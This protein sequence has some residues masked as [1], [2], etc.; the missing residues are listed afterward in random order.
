MARHMEQQSRINTGRAGRIFFVISVAIYI[1]VN[2]PETMTTYDL[3]YD[4]T[5]SYPPLRL[6]LSHGL[7]HALC[8]CTSCERVEQLIVWRQSP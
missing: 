5:D 8:S 4:T 2:A 3:S 7:E 1:V 6:L